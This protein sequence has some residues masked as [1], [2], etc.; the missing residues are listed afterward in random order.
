M[1]SAG[2]SAR[3]QDS[4]SAGGRQRI[5]RSAWTR[6]NACADHVA[7]VV[8][9]DGLHEREQIIEARVEPVRAQRLE[10]HDRFFRIVEEP[11]G[12][13]MQEIEVRANGIR[14]A[15]SRVD[16]PRIEIAAGDRAIEEREDRDQIERKR[17]RGFDAKGGLP[18]NQVTHRERSFL[19]ESR[20]FITSS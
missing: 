1:V 13:A 14:Q 11:A 4:S 20:A 17:D 8:G 16:Q 19:I 7:I 12:E 9:R 6:S 15:A 3:A 10:A 2:A 5:S 18:G